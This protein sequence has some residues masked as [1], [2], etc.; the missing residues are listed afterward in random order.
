MEEKVHILL[1][2]AE[3]I[4]PVDRICERTIKRCLKALEL[5][6]TG[7]YDYILITG[8]I[9]LPPN[10]QTEPASY[11]IKKYLA[12]KVD[13]SHIIIEEKSRTTFE[14]AGFGLNEL[15]L[16][17]IE[18]FD[19]TVVTQWQH[20]LRFGLTFMAYGHK[21]R[22]EKVKYRLKP[23]EWLREWAYILIHL[24]DPL[25]RSKAVK[26]FTENR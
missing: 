14:N 26:K 10:V 11:L 25:G 4:D 1:L 19:L 17:C 7:N 3:C 5:W 8:G 9:F 15:S 16:R 12:G 20:A 6:R 24:V 13:S 22:S 18:D 2:P 23:S 21:I